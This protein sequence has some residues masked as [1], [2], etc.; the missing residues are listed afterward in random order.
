LTWPE[1]FITDQSNGF[2]KSAFARCG[3]TLPKTIHDEQI[4]SDP[5]QASNRR[6]VPPA[7]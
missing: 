5:T 2:D 3:D 4:S 7:H 1:P 6:I